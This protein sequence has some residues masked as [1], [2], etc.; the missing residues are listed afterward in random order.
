MTGICSLI[1]V[2]IAQVLESYFLQPLV[3]GKTMKLHP[4]T[5][6]IGLLVFGSFFGI[7]GMILATPVI[8]I[9]KTIAIFFDEKFSLKER[10]TS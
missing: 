1:A 10:I 8:S 3:M 5:I 2:V 4:V 7:V 9:V 6:M